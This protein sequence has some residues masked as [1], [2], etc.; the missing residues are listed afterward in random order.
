MR[1][2]V[3]ALAMPVLMCASGIYAAGAAWW[4]RRYP[5]PPPYSQAGLRLAGERAVAV[6]EAVVAD[7]YA[8]FAGAVGCPDDRGAGDVH[9]GNRRA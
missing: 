2:V 8:L 1:D 6:A 5:A 7:E 3:L 9:T 4:R